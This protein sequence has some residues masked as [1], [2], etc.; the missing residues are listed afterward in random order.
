MHMAGGFV[1][2]VMRCAGRALRRKFVLEVAKMQIDRVLLDPQT[3]GD[4]HDCVLDVEDALLV[5]LADD[6][7]IAVGGENIR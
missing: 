7:L 3:G 1:L 4:I 2:S 6:L 5:E